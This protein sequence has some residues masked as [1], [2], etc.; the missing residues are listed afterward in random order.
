MKWL[1]SPTFH[2][3]NRRWWILLG[4]LM[5]VGPVWKE[6]EVTSLLSKG[7]PCCMVLNVLLLLIVL[8]QAHLCL[9]QLLL[10]HASQYHLSYPAKCPVWYKN[11]RLLVAKSGNTL[12]IP[13]KYVKFFNIILYPFCLYLTELYSWQILQVSAVSRCGGENLQ[14]F[15]VKTGPYPGF[16]TDLQPQIMA[17]LTTCNGLSPVEESVFDKRMGHGMWYLQ[18]YMCMHFCIFL[19]ADHFWSM[20]CISAA[21][22]SIYA[23]CLYMCLLI[24]THHSFCFDVWKAD[25]LL[26]IGCIGI[27]TYMFSAF[28]Q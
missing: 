11:S 12:M 10:A 28:Y 8:K 25:I 6:Q 4:F 24:H 26:T 15:E 23:L 27:F 20:D 18:I 1:L 5:T 13:W 21:P 16:P 7:N 22:C 19:L 3:R 17:L 2:H 14:S 9:L